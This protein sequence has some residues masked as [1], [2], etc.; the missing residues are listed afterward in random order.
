MR[1][2]FSVK[3]YLRSHG[4][5]TLLSKRAFFLFDQNLALA[6]VIGLTDDAFEFHPL[7]QR[8]GA[9]ISDLQP[10]L[11]VAGGSLAVPLDDSH[12]LRKQIASAFTA[13]G[14]G[15]EQRAALFVGGFFRGDCLEIFR[16]T[17]RLQMPHNFLDLFVR[18]EGPVHAADPATARH[19]KHIALPEQ[20][21]GA[22]FAEDGAAVDLR[23]DLE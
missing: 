5:K 17:L 9:I 12:R 16:L 10:A 7:H 13:H 14:R 15:I 11:N 1:H 2:R 8:G 23:G 22:H 18:N 4:L 3:Q 19:I 21:F 20:L 6:G